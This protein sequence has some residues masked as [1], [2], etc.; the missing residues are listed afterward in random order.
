MIPGIPL[1]ILTAI[2]TAYL[3]AQAKARDLWQNP[4]LPPHLVRPVGAAGFFRDVLVRRSWM[5]RCTS[6][7]RQ[8]EATALGFGLSRFG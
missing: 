7:D 2:Y 1:A 3:F 8:F 6:S 5:D 4:L